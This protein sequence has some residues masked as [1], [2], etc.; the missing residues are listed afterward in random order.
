MTAIFEATPIYLTQSRLLGALLSAVVLA[1][2]FWLFERTE[3]AREATE[4]KRKD[5][6]SVGVAMARGMAY[7]A[8]AALAI[9]IAAMILGGFLA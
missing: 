8:L 3:A 9:V 1:F 5:R 2:V 7:G 6:D 4:L